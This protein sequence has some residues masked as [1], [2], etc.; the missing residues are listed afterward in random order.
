MDGE[1]V[2]AVELRGRVALVVGNEG[3]GLR[4]QTRLHV[5]RLVSI[6]MSG[7]TESLNVGVAAGILLYEFSRRQRRG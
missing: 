1:P 6:P 5:A 7:R 4:E 3:G 2:D